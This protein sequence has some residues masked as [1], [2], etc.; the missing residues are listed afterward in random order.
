MKVTESGGSLLIFERSASGERLRCTFNLSD[1]EAP[2]AFGGKEL[3]RAGY[4]DAAT[5]GPYSAI[6]EEIA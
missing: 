2:F 6:I 5:L 1:R 4:V 3:I